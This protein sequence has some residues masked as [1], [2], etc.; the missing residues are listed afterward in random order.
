MNTR[1]GRYAVSRVGGS[2]DGYLPFVLLEERR[3]PVVDDKVLEEIRFH[4]NVVEHESGS[5]LFQIREKE[6]EIS[7]RMLSAKK[8]A[9]DI[10]ANAR[11]KAVDTVSKAESKGDKLA[12]DS[13]EKALADAAKEAV[14]IRAKAQ[15]D[16][17]AL[18]EAL[19]ARSDDA[20]RLIVDAVTQV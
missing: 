17:A 1:T 2:G 16:A 9:D 13:E 3:R 20:A 12:K 19:A 7:G 8:Q 6:M 5:P 18:E 4:Q 14:A 10:V 11:R 15:K